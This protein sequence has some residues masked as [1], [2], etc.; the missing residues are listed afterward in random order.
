[1]RCKRDHLLDAHRLARSGI[2]RD[3]LL[4]VVLRLEESSPHVDGLIAAKDGGAGGFGDVAVRL[5]ALDL[6]RDDVGAERLRRDRVEV[7]ALELR[8][9]DNAAVCH[10]TVDRRDDLDPAGPVLWRDHPLD[11]RL[12]MVGHADEATT[13]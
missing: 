13:T 7:A 8:I 2:A 10:P 3:H 9:A 12:V 11:G 4:D 6:E 5:A 1:V